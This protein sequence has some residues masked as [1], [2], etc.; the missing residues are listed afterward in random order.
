MPDTITL[1]GEAY[2]VVPLKFRDLKRILGLTASAIF[3]SNN[4]A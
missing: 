2:P 4:S 1:A 3:H